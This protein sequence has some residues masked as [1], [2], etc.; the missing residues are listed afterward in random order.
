MT[1]QKVG[2]LKVDP[3]MKFMLTQLAQ[4][5]A[6]L[7]ARIVSQ[8]LTTAGIVIFGVGSPLAKT[9]AAIANYLVG[10]VFRQIAASTSLPALSGTTATTLYNFYAW[11][12]DSTGTLTSVMG[13]AGATLA[14]AVF[15]AC[16]VGSTCVGYVLIHPTGTGSFIGGTTNLDDATVVPNA[17]FVS[18]T[19]PFNPGAVAQIIA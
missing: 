6:E 8:M 17:V 11:F 9:G 12:A 14:A 5:H 1:Q 10:G 2:A 4:D 7:F 19:G 15:P 16:P 3:D 18:P 13:T